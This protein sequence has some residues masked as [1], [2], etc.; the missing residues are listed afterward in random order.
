MNDVTMTP[1]EYLGSAE[2][3][4]K[5]AAQIETWN[6]F[7][8]EHGK[9][10]NFFDVLAPSDYEKHHSDFIKAL[11]D[12]SVLP[13]HAPR[14]LSFF[15]EEAST[16]HFPESRGYS[17]RREFHIKDE[18][19]K[20]RYLDI[21]IESKDH[22]GIHHAVAIENKVTAGSDNHQLQR[23]MD[24]LSRNYG[25]AT[26]I[27]LAPED[28]TVDVQV[29]EHENAELRLIAYKKGAI[30]EHE[31]TSDNNEEE[32]DPDNIGDLTNWLDR[33]LS[34]VVLLPRVREVL[35][36]YEE[37]AKRVG[38]QKMDDRE[39][40]AYADLI[41]DRRYMVE[42]QKI[43]EALPRLRLQ[44][45]EKFWYDLAEI[46]KSNFD[47]Q[48]DLKRPT[49]EEIR[50]F[51]NQ[52]GSGP[53]WVE[54]AF[55]PYAIFKEWGIKISLRVGKHQPKLCFVVYRPTS[56][57][58]S[59]IKDDNFNEIFSGLRSTGLVSDNAVWGP[60]A[61]FGGEIVVRGDRID[62]GQFSGR[63]AD[64]VETSGRTELI[65][66]VFMCAK[67]LVDSIPKGWLEKSNED[68]NSM[69][70]Q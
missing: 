39:L 62:L 31:K 59:P 18:S 54:V 52:Q 24:W 53:R 12:P 4:L 3:L 21:L 27:L 41:A 28:Q 70:S 30:S 47:V 10:F 1:N 56:L 22:K 36:Q 48:D 2:E 5:N 43:A 44:A 67:E 55:F 66:D 42:A 40:Q 29:R 25:C 64:A 68:K 51:V 16:K 11:L 61:F 38:G 20:S 57:G 7:E 17:I 35:A 34:E 50:K 63:A 45:H 65:Q 49:S 23:Y 37:I 58:S 14:F 9:N 32:G 60:R 26:L 19:Q 46:I 69:V 13:Q 33:C 15:C 6:R 8:R